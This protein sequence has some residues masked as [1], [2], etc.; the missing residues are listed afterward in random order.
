[1]RNA[2]EQFACSIYSSTDLAAWT[3]RGYIPVNKTRDGSN[4]GEAVSA[5]VPS[6]VHLVSIS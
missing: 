1:M 4:P 6:R 3:K 2:P 5:S